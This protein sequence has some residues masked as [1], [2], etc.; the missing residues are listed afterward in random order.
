MWNLRKRKTHTHTNELNLFNEHCLF[1][2]NNR[3]WIDSN[4]IEWIRLFIYLQ[5]D[6]KTVCLFIQSIYWSLWLSS[7]PPLS[8]SFKCLVYFVYNSSSLSSLSF[9]HTQC[10]HNRFYCQ[11]QNNE[12]A[13]CIYTFFSILLPLCLRDFQFCLFFCSLLNWYIVIALAIELRLYAR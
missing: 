3:I 7:F 6:A 10:T 5:T 12:P 1:T 11:I 8:F 9:T 13:E 2:S 4:R